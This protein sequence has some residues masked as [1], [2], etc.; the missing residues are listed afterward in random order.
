[1]LSNEQLDELLQE[2]QQRLSLVYRNLDKRNKAAAKTRRWGFM[3][4]AA[5]IGALFLFS[6][7][8]LQESRVTA[9]LFIGVGLGWLVR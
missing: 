1:M 7:F 2:T 5:G 6:Y 8:G 3:L 4:T 9:V